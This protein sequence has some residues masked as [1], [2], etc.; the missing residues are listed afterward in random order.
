MAV[1]ILPATGAARPDAV[2]ILAP[3]RSDG[4]RHDQ[5]RAATLKPEKERGLGPECSFSPQQIIRLPSTP[6]A[7]GAWDHEVSMAASGAGQGGSHRPSRVDLAQADG[8]FAAALNA[9]FEGCH[10]P[11]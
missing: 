6:R 10:V 9:P 3:T 5:I 8:T 4:F 11:S 7:K 2:L 1:A